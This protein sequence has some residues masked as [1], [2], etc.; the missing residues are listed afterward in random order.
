MI[1]PDMMFADWFQLVD[2]QT[3]I[4]ECR[5]IL[6]RRIEPG[7]FEAAGVLEEVIGITGP[8]A[9]MLDIATEYHYDAVQ[10][11]LAGKQAHEVKKTELD[12][13]KGWPTPEKRFLE[14]CE[15]LMKTAEVRTS[16]LQTLVKRY[17]K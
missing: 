4:K 12:R 3:K 8:A 1:K 15:R 11:I 5:E 9:E 10:K 17:T 6:Q 7:Q 16:A 13:A 14:L 2:T